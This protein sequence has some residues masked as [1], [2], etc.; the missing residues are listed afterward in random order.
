MKI[1]KG[2][3]L[4]QSIVKTMIEDLLRFLDPFFVSLL[5][6]TSQTRRSVHC[7][8]SCSSA[9][10]SCPA[11]LVR[12]GHQTSPDPRTE[13]PEPKLAFHAGHA[14]VPGGRVRTD[15]W[16]R[17]AAAGEGCWEPGKWAVPN[18]PPA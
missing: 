16:T 2:D 13:A 6:V 5:S 10:L 3:P 18:A 7:S 12:T 1:E 9:A 8:C 4:H 14:D 11:P 17:G 15:R